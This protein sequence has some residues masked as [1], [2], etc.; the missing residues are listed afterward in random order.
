M[1]KNLP[2]LIAKSDTISHIGKIE[3]IVGMTIEA[4]CGKASIG[5]IGMI[6]SEN[7]NQHIPA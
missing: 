6:Y 7:K 2:K 5:D 3:N 4:S 1:L